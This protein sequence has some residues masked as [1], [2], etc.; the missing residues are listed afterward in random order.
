VVANAQHV[1]KVGAQDR[2]ERCGMDRGF[3]L[4]GLLRSSFVPPQPSGN[5]GIDAFIV[6]SWWKAGPRSATAAEAAGDPNIKLASVATD[7]FGVS[8]RLML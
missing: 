4:H 5:S 6:A 3:A 8:G 7:V 2:R 1:K